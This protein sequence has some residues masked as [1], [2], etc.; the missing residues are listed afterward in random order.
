VKTYLAELH[1]HTV[2]SPCADVE[3]IPPLIVEE[4][5]H[6]NIQMIAI[7]DHN[8][9]ANCAAVQ[10]AAQGTGLTVLPGMEVQTRE[11][12]HVLC[13][14]ATLEQAEQWQLQVD[15]ALPPFRNDPEH[16][17]EQFVVDE[18]GNFI[19]K[20][21]RLLLTSI[22]LSFEEACERVHALGGMFIPAHVD[23]RAFGLI[24]NL[25]FVPLDASVDALE[26]SRHLRPELASQ[27]YPQ[28]AGYPLLQGGD[29][30]RLEECL[31]MNVFSI[32]APTLAELRLAFCGQDGRGLNIRPALN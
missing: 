19:S 3:M 14:F 10:K 2:L 1:V 8:A 15:A 9:T 6:R 23:R 17:G 16:F 13:L 32:E 21:T 12:V 28:L 4:A 11:E 22:A 24:A 7:T 18:T 29:A 25:G 30:H 27:I 31:G 20:E 5:L 26:V